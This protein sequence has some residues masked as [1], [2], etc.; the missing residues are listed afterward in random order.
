MADR[1]RR[2]GFT[3]TFTIPDEDDI[4]DNLSIALLEDAPGPAEETDTSSLYNTNETI[5]AFFNGS[6]NPT[7]ENQSTTPPTPTPNPVIPIVATT[8]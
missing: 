3:Q 7:L 5:A 1:P 4:Y 2:S 6:Y 8:L